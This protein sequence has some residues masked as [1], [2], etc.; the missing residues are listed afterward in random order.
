MGFVPDDLTSA[1]AAVVAYVARQ[2]GVDPEALADYGARAHTRTDHL[3][4]I[5]AYLGYRK[6]IGKDLRALSTWLLDRALEHDKPTLLYALACEKLHAA[7]CLRPGITRLERLVAEVRQQAQTETLRRLAPLLTDPCRSLLD[8]L[9]VP[10]AATDRTPLTWLRQHATSNSPTAIVATLE[11]LAWLRGWGVDGW[12]LSAL[13]PNRVKFLAQLRRRTTNQALQRA[14][15]AR[16]YPILLAFVHQSL[17]DLTDEALDL[18]AGCLAET[19]ARAGREL[20]E[21]RKAAAW[22][23][24]DKL[25]LFRDLG[26]LV[27]DATVR[28]AELRTTIYRRIPPERLHAAV[29]ECE[30]LIRPFDDNAFEFLERR[31]SYL[32]QFTPAFLGLLPPVCEILL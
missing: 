23:T 16:R 19:V 28:D 7:Q 25:Q 10:D 14:P 30:E 22:T 13:T 12:D 21:F 8:H 29:K 9:L 20:D 31:Y 11:K 24:H 32:R 15:E 18:F 27:L 4:T 2:L 5:Q 17:I 6:A 3:Q 26:R 1:P